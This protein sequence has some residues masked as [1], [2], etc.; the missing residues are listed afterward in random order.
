MTASD[1]VRITSTV[2]AQTFNIYP[3]KVMHAGGGKR[4]GGRCCG[5]AVLRAACN[6]HTHARPCIW[7]YGQQVDGVVYR[8][9]WVYPSPLV[10]VYPPP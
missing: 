4:A 3:R 2:A 7:G 10:Q 6:T 5:V 9:T 1:F 8:I